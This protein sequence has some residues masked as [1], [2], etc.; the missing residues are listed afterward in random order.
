MAEKEKKL[1]DDLA[2]LPD[3]LQNDFV[4][5]LH[6]AA[7]AVRVLA[8]DNTKEVKDNGDSSG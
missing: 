7:A 3:A 5:Q 6:G 8:G 4:A 2:A 1:L